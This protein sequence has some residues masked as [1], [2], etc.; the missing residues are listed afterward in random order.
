[1]I[2]NQVLDNAE[3]LRRYMQDLKNWEADMKWKDSELH[4]TAS[5]DHICVFH[6][7][8]YQENVLTFSTH[9]PRQNSASDICSIRSF[10]KAN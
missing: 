10:A 4:T 2:Q 1:M 8:F 9:I 7:L 5:G 3:G 6:Y